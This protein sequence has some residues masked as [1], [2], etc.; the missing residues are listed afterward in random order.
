MRLPCSRW[1]SRVGHRVSAT[2]SPKLVTAP[3]K[4]Q[5]PDRPYSQRTRSAYSSSSGLQFFF[6]RSGDVLTKNGRKR[7]PAKSLAIRRGDL[8]AG[9][10][11]VVNTLRQTRFEGADLDKHS[12]KQ[13]CRA[14]R[15]AFEDGRRSHNR[16]FHPDLCRDRWLLCSV[17]CRS[18]RSPELTVSGAYQS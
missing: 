15:V 3:K 11:E 4:R 9:V 7:Q 13:H 2:G 5:I 10:G 18:R 1:C 16:R 17:S 6:L 8:D 14:I 12:R